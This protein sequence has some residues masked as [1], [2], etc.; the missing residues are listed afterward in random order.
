MCVHVCASVSVWLCLR[1]A[2]FRSHPSRCTQSA[3]PPPGLGRGRGSSSRRAAQCSPK[4]GC[5]LQAQLLVVCCTLRMFVV[6][7][8]GV[9]MD[10]VIKQMLQK[11]EDGQ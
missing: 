7:G 4:T 2:L 9:A 6:N 3:S 5:C 10:S 1:G 11:G 8:E